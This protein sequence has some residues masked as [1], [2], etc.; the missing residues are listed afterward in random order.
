[1][2]ALS[3]SG[4]DAVR[5]RFPVL[6][7]RPGFV[8]PHHHYRGEYEDDT[9]REQARRRLGLSRDAPVMVFFG[10]VVEYKNL[11]ALV[12]AT[13]SL[14]RTEGERELRLVIAGKPRTERLER[15]LRAAS[16]GD[17]R[18]VL[19]L[20]RVPRDQAQVFL[21]AADLVVLPYREIL[22]SGSAVLALSFDRPVLMPGLGAAHDLRAL[23][24]DEWIYEYRELSPEVLASNLRAVLGRPDRAGD[25]HLRALDPGSIADQTLAAYRTLV[26]A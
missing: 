24:G 13:R 10:R 17:S 22:N 25:A 23:V 11:P 19:E 20:S 2:I 3:A 4:L 9:G 5:A 8:I 21:R 16:A 6:A 14:P 18:I 15:E 26:S 7:A 1:V 12:E